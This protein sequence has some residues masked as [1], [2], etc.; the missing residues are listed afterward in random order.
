MRSCATIM[1]RGRKEQ[2]CPTCLDT[3]LA[4]NVRYKVVSVT[5]ARRNIYL[6]FLFLYLNSYISK[7]YIK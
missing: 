2:V 4:Y 1:Q 7:M 5:F 6:T 3:R